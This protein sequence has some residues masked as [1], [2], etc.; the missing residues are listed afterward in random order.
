M[1]ETQAT[2][3][4]AIQEALA[5]VDGQ[6]AVERT[7]A[8]EYYHGQPFGDEVKGRSQAVVTVVRD[9]I[10]GVLPS[11]LRVLHGPEH[12]V[13]FQPKRA[14]AVAQAAQATDA[15][16]YIYEEDNP[17][18]LITHNAL[19]DGLLKK[20]GVVKWGLDTTPEM[21]AQSFSGIS[22]DDVLALALDPATRI[23]RAVPMDGE[24]FHVETL[25]TVP[26]GR[27][28]VQV[29]PPDDIF[30][31]REARGLA[32][33]R[34]FGHRMRPTRGELLAMG[35][36]EDDLDA[37][38]G[39]VT[40]TSQ[41][42][43]EQARRAVSGAA[44]TG[45]DPTMGENAQRVLY[46]EVYAYL[47][48]ED[49]TGA[50]IEGAPSTLR[51]LCTIG[52]G[53]HIVKDEPADT[54]PFAVFSPDPEPHAMLGGSYF[55][56]LKDQQR[57]QSQLLR[58][59]FDSATAAAFPRTAYV[60]GQ[61]SVADIMNVALGQPIRMRQ[62]GMV[63]PLDVPFTAD[64]LIP[65]MAMQ[66]EIVERRIGNK[67]GAGSLDIDALQSTG[68]EAV[69]AA[70]QAATSQAELLTRLFAE[71]VL[72]PMFRGI[73]RLIAHPASKARLLRLRGQYVEVDP[74][75]W[76]AT[77]DVTVNVALGAMSIEK[78]AMVLQQIINDQTGIIQQYGPAN[79]VVTVPML[80]NA[81]A[82]WAKLQGIS[83]VDAYYKS[84]PDD[85]QPPPPPPP[86]PTPDQLWMQT[87]KEMLLQKSVKE[88]AIKQ[89]ELQF[90]RDKAAQDA[91]FKERELAIK[92]ASL[93]DGQHG[94]EV[95]TYKAD[96]AA[97]VKR[98]EIASNA[99]L[100]EQELAL[101]REK[102]ALERDRM[103]HEARLA[104]AAP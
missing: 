39:S 79:P 17:G 52:D 73:L 43:E 56:R 88:L 71:Q 103:A 1:T 4:L 70:L 85:W 53:H 10:T 104:K 78:K 61:V 98:E 25:T 95:E 81:K 24:L 90:Q 37:Y 51:R 91:D 80:R 99:A 13:T 62:P 92:A 82:E 8:T 31:N 38:G 9:G 12:V 93:T 26:G 47:P 101:E 97:A 5:Y 45:S 19:K 96:L 55:D 35:V 21:H 94:T 54:I 50:P 86:Q 66:Q 63:Q 67:D 18:F 2:V 7:K 23:T 68:K 3:R 100:R 89:D 83:A 6:L 22:R 41:T 33:C 77:M 75:A 102:I 34:L 15:V 20:C 44:R 58:L 32:D 36:S 48:P 57:I 64:K 74:K 84:L 49:E 40:A 27:V 42:M 60:D 87:E 65:V 72:K 16:R 76:D 59:I 46:C 29:C 69:Q 28:W 30:W 14:D 11:V